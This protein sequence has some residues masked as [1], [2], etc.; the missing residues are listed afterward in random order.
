VQTEE[1][2]PENY[3]DFQVNRPF[4]GLGPTGKREITWPTT[5]F[6]EAN[7]PN[8]RIILL[9]GVEPSFRWRSY[10]QEVLDFAATAEVDT[11]ITMGALLADVPH[12]RP[13]PLTATSESE[14][15]RAVLS[16][17]ESNTYEGPTGIVGVLQHAAAERGFQAVSLWAAVP[18]YV[19]HSPSPKATLALI[20]R[21]A[22][23]TGHEIDLGDLVDESE[24]WQ[25]DL[26]VMFEDDDDIREYIA[27]L[28]QAR[29][30]ADSPEASGEAI[31]REFERWLSRGG[32]KD[33]RAGHTP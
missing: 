9:H 12:T 13:I 7:L 6:W 4:V 8:R 1:L 11:I 25:R 17:V 19:G 27:E 10:C 3:H 14:S 16:D 15:L 21:I 32:D 18:H 2:D 30:T 24:Q 20:F 28:E 22:E 33:P 31:A 26:D 23:L 5:T 29:D